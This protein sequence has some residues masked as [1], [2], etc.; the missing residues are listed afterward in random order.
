MIA[1]LFVCAGAPATVFGQ[2]YATAQLGYASADFNLGAPYNGVIDDRAMSLGADIGVNLSDHFAL[3]LGVTKYNSFSGRATPC[4]A[5]LACPLVV[6][7]T[8]S[9]DIVAY[10]FSIVPHV[11]LA[12]VELFAEL[13][14][15]GARVDT[16]IGLPDSKF[17]ERGVLLG[18]G[19][20]WYFREPWSVS[21]EGSR[22][23]DN[24]YQIAVGAGWGLRL[25]SESNAVPERSARRALR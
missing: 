20:R 17:T 25:G 18:V 4:A 3:E 7:S 10:N 19:A 16:Q 2:V 6:Q 15:Y 14:Y 21:L 12:D 8:G 13:G 23:D 9:N 24:I 5:G 11:E 22:L 1:V